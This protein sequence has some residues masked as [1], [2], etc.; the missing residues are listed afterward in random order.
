[1]AR[2]TPL[3]PDMTCRLVRYGDLTAA[4]LDKWRMLCRTHETYDSALLQPEFAYLVACV[5]DDV[6]IALYETN[7]RLDAVLAIHLRPDGLARPLGAP[8]SDYS[9][10]VFHPSSQLVLP[11]ML[12]A[13]GIAAYDA[14]ATPDP[15]SRIDP[16]ADML[17]QP[18]S[19]DS[20]VIRLNGVSP[21][22]LLETQRAAHPKRFKNFRRLASQIQRDIGE[23]QLSWG[24]PDETTLETLLAFKSEQYR[25]SGY[26]DLTT[27]TQSRR[28][29]QAVATSEHGFCLSLKVKDTLVSGHFGVKVGTAFHPWIA[30]FNPAFGHYSPGNLLLLN[31]L[32]SLD[33]MGIETYDLA[34]GHD[35][36]KKYF[37]NA[38]RP[39]KP[40]FATGHGLRAWRHTLNRKVWKL[41]G[42]NAPFSLT[43][44]LKRRM[45]QIAV[46][47]FAVLP[48]LHAFGYA[49]MSR[50]LLRKRA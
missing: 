46:S 8:F 24:R 21:A 41:A 45:D 7:E 3:P 26:V 16:P 5:R 30:A 18:E 22:T 4:D 39:A 13:A 12:S 19:E 25:A 38:S 9:G 6:R 42:A 37:A 28:L 48:R 1:M 29:L 34:N 49:L 40:V 23:L 33:R 27:A 10:P 2:A 32:Q 20:H 43:A 35:H 36:Y 14:P 15:W 50:T 11:D 44:R 31:A 47:E 17:E